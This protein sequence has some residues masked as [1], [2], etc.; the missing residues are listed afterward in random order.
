MPLTNTA[1][2]TNMD[3][4]FAGCTSLV[5]APELDTSAVTSMKHMYEG[6]TNLSMVPESDTSKVKSFEYAFAGCTSLSEDFPIDNNGGCYALDLAGVESI[7]GLTGMFD[8]TKVSVIHVKNVCPEIREKVNQIKFSMD[9]KGHYLYIHEANG[10]LTVV[11]HIVGSGSV[12]YLNNNQHISE[13][14]FIQ[15]GRQ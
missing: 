4:M 12:K 11:E 10:T 6:D 1:N 3:Y 15:L 7:D 13:A 14:Q 2:V 8:N 5:N 9:I